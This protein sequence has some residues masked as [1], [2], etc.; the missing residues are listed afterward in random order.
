MKRK[1][2]KRRK[3]FRVRAAIIFA[4]M[5][6]LLTCFMF[7]KPNAAEKKCNTYSVYTVRGGDSLWGIC[8]KV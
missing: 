1:N 7:I 3:E 5:I 2:Y 8:R 4:L 6:L